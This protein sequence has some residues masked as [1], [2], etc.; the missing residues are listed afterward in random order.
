MT[1]ILKVKGNQLHGFSMTMGTE[2]LEPRSE[3]MEMSSLDKSN[4]PQPHPTTFITGALPVAWYQA[5]TR[6]QRSHRTHMDIPTVQCPN[7][8]SRQVDRHHNARVERE[9]LLASVPKHT[10]ALEDCCFPLDWVENGA[11]STVEWPQ[12]PWPPPMVG[13]TTWYGVAASPSGNSFP[14]PDPSFEQRCLPR[15]QPQMCAR[16]GP[17]PF[18][19]PLGFSM[20]RDKEFD[21]WKGSGKGKTGSHWPWNLEGIA[22]DGW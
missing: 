2:S 14:K 5:Q 7:P 9:G 4:L 11:S 20:C 10:G 22:R 1:F 19:T 17:Q 15:T 3:H 18:A 6:C 16:G 13:A 12:P 8:Q 21:G